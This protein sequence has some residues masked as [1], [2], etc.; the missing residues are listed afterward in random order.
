MTRWFVLLSFL[1]LS[2]RSVAQDIAVLLNRGAQLEAAFRE[3][4]ALP[5]YEKAAQLQPG[6]IVALIHCSDLLCRVG[7]RLKDRDKMIAYFRSAYTYAQ[8]AYRIDSANSE[9]NVVMAFS[10]ARLA[11]DQSG[12]E[13]VVSANEIRRLAEQAI[14]DDPGNF[15]AYHILGRWHFEVSGLNFVE[16]TL[17]RW[18]F[19]TLPES[20]LEECISNLERSK[21]LR[22]DFMLNYFELA[23]A[24]HREG[25]NGRAIALL[26]QMERLPDVM[27]DDRTVR[28][29]G[30][31]LLKELR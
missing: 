26:T 5:L 21:A 29:Q 2:S 4:E 24:Y 7:H 23:R 22:P 30:E 17:A 16:R 13:R 9:A 18:F 19:G 11:L 10:L 20:S 31:K 15:K 25:Q 1:F 28:E 3:D 6:N 27:Y 14:R 12:K 8:R